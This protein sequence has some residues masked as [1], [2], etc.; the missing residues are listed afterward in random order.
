MASVV[1]ALGP[2]AVRLTRDEATALASALAA[3]RGVD[4][5]RLGRGLA[6]AAAAGGEIRL[7]ERGAR[8]AYRA[9]AG[10]FE[11]APWVTDGLVR[12]YHAIRE[13]LRDGGLR[14]TPP[15]DAGPLVRRP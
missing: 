7:D 9:L 1:I 5:H 6:Q 12:L 3:G 2:V 8:S 15:A 13:A 4:D 11:R 14:A 10:P